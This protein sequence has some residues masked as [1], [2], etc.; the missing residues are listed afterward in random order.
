MPRRPRILSSNGFYHVIVRGINKLP[1]LATDQEKQYFLKA[2]SRM[3]KDGE[4]SVHA[5]CLMNNH[6]HLLLKTGC[7]VLAESMKR[8]NVSF[9]YYYN[10]LHSRTGP[11]LDNRYKSV[12]IEDEAQLLVCARYIHNNPVKAGIASKPETYP[13]SS[14][15]YYI[16]LDSYSPVPISTQTLL[17][18][19]HPETN[20]AIDNLIAFTEIEDLPDSLQ[21]SIEIILRR[22]DVRLEDVKG[23]PQQRRNEIIRA[24]MAQTGARAKDISE[25]LGLSSTVIYKAKR[26]VGQK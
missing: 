12:V 4:Y 10:K 26:T 22:E 17:S 8:I 9:V 24:I 11:L 20:K 5:Y 14:Y 23:L 1:I 13:W 25:I 15:R 2:L 18:R 19:F 21:N 16:G 7:M 3:G 6:A